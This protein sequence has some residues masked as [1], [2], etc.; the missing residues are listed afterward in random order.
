MS[1]LK[2]HSRD[3]GKGV[4]LSLLRSPLL[5][6]AAVPDN[7][8]VAVLVEARVEVE[9]NVGAL[10]GQVHGDPGTQQ[11]RQRVWTHRPSWSFLSSAARS[12]IWKLWCLS[13]VKTW[14]V[15][16]V[17]TD[18]LGFGLMLPVMVITSWSQTPL[19]R[20]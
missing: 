16:L 8:L 12:G 3:E 15:S 6:D 4:Q 2:R 9:G 13:L 10:G 7:H 18:M 17:P 11:N 1:D 20:F 19:E 5:V 14:K